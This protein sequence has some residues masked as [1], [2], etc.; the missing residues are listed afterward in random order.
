MSTLTGTRRS[1]L[2]SFP[3]GSFVHV[4][5]VPG[6]S[7]A[8]R[9][10][11][12]RAA[13]R[14]SIVQIRR[15]L[16]YRGEM[17]RYGMTHPTE[18]EI[19]H[20]VVGTTGVGPAGYAAARALGVTTQVPAKLE[21]SAVG[22]LPE[23]LPGVILY[24]RSNRAR[25]RLNEPEIALLEVLRSWKTLVEGGWK[26]LVDAVRRL[27]SRGKLR[28]DKVQSAVRSEHN[29]AIREAFTRLIESLQ[30]GTPAASVG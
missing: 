11:L 21:Y 27:T 24:S 16:Y 18:V 26:A 23:N 10:A 25:L 12:S 7:D 13:K 28:I 6:S 2:D 29:S 4:Q 3:A 30:T 19:V 22:P 9:A 1:W 15:G 5:D 17:T 14:G 20:E 8:A